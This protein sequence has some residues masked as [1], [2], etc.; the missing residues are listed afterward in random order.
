ME[1]KHSETEKTKGLPARNEIDPKYKWRLEDLYP[2]DEAWERDCNRVKELLP[3]LE[4]CKG[5]LGKSADQLLQALKLRDEIFQLNEKLFVYARMRRDEDNTNGHYQALTDRASGL[6]VRVR[7]AASFLVPEILAIPEERLRRFLAENGE[8]A[9]YKHEL[10]EIVRQKEHVLSP[11][12]E[13]ILAQAGELAQAPRDIFTMLN[14]ADIKFPT[15]RDENGDEVELTK[16]RY[17]LFLESA[18]RRV[19]RDAFK[20]LYAT[21]EKQ[22][23]TLAA[24]L[25]ASVKKD[26]FY[27]KVRKYHSSLEAA[28]DGDN[29]PVSVYENLLATV[30]E[31]LDQMHRY[32]SLRK[33]LLGLEELHMYDL[34]APLVPEVKLK[35]PYEEAVATVKESLSPLGE[36]YLSRLEEAFCS[37]WID[38]YENRGKTGGAYA[39]GAYGTHPYV[40]LNYQG[41]LNDMFTLAH[42]MGHALHSSY[43]NETQPYVYAHY[44]I[45]VAEVASTVNEALLMEHLLKTVTDRKQKLYLLNY[46]LEQF[47]GTVYR[48]TMFAE[49]EK[50]IHETVEAGEGLTPELLCGLYRELNEAYYGPDIVVDDEIEMEWARIPHFYNDFYVYKYATGFSAAIALSRKIL[51]EGR[52]AADKYLSF[53]KSGSSD[54]P[55]ELL[56]KAGVDMTSPE[57]IRNALQVFKETL[58]E[59]ERLTATM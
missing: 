4:G 26:V 5:T 12:E 18:D 38:V 44:T 57:P 13:L 39:W 42:E 58:D 22:K 40:L 11:E 48:Q 34:Y 33:R 8:L 50:R 55:L 35:I 53:L 6:S 32:V 46:F 23:N 17:I 54:Y 56:K 29:I 30:R 16:G 15:I 27:A 41:Q 2:S 7:S 19:R 51:Q 49:F 1:I 9:L 28:L 47:R 3:Q 59:M 43:S 31:H 20:A 52:P 25:N 45:F 21:Y 37:G 24:I 14:D 10:D 36:N